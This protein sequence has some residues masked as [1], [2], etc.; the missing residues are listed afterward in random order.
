MVCAEAILASRPLVAS[1]VCPAIEDLQDASVEV[2]PDNVNE[3]CQAIL[4]L[5]DE[6]E[7]YCQKQSACIALHEPFY[8]AE[9]SWS[10]KIKE[11]ISKHVS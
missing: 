2:Q 10:T 11:A 9:N 5:S 4:R 3:Y 8:N 1:A 6:R 7:F